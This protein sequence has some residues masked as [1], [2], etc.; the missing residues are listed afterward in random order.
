MTLSKAAK[1]QRE[2][3]RLIK[4]QVWATCW[5]HIKYRHAINWLRFI[6]IAEE[7]LYFY[8]GEPWIEECM[9]TRVEVSLKFGLSERKIL[10]ILKAAKKLP[11]WIYGRELIDIRYVLAYANLA[12]KLNILE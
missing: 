6:K 12:P 7:D 9:F 5:T 8:K 2:R 3:L 11:T 1:A 4:K 10:D